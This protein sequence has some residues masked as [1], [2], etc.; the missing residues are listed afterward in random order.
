MSAFSIIQAD[1]TVVNFN[2]SPQ[3][4]IQPTGAGAVALP[5]YT[6]QNITGAG[7]TTD[8]NNNA[9]V[10]VVDTAG[11]AETVRLP[12]P[13]RADVA[14]G[15]ADLAEGFL[16]YVCNTGAGANAVTVQTRSGGNPV[17]G[18]SNIPAA[19]GGVPLI[20]GR[21]YMVVD[22]AQQDGWAQVVL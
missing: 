17:T 8:I 21:T 5:Q 19:G 11:G 22:S 12:D 14:A 6:R 18:A 20:N 16:L 9:R 13:R 10:A 7:G 2:Y 15:G 4:N 3:Q 1:G